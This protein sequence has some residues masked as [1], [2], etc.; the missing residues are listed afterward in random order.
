MSGCG[1]SWTDADRS[2]AIERQRRI[3]AAERAKAADAKKA[4]RNRKAR[5]RYAKRKAAKDSLPY[6]PPVTVPAVK[7]FA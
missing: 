7:V 2:A 4:E 3:F 6:L 5:E 1:G